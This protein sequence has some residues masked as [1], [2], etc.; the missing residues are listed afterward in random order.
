M[1]SLK[2]KFDIVLYPFLPKN[3]MESLPEKWSGYKST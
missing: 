1:I 2:L 3:F